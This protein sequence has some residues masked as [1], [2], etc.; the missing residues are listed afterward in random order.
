MSGHQTTQNGA[1]PS[2]NFPSTVLKVASDVTFACTCVF[3]D[4][5]CSS[6]IINSDAIYMQC[7]SLMR[8]ATLTALMIRDAEQHRPGHNLYLGLI[9][10]ATIGPPA[11]VMAMQK[12]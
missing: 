1:A 5:V 11:A 2:Q 9:Q 12:Y 7:E 10:V 3:L 4:E 8:A 6:T